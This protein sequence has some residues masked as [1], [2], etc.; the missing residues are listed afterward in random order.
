MQNGTMNRG[1]VLEAYGEGG[2]IPQRNSSTGYGHTGTIS[3][4]M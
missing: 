4:K 3:L 2:L 1:K